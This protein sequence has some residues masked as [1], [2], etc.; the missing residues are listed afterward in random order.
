M[1]CLWQPLYCFHFV[2]V[3]W[4]HVTEICIY[5]YMYVNKYFELN[6]S[7]GCCPNLNYLL[8]SVA[9]QDTAT[10]HVNEEGFKKKCM[11][12]R[13][14]S[15]CPCL[16]E[17][18]CAHTFCVW[19]HCFD[20]L[21]C[22]DLR[23]KTA[24]SSSWGSSPMSFFLTWNT[25]FCTC[26]LDY[27]CYMQVACALVYNISIELYYDLLLMFI[28]VLSFAKFAKKNCLKNMATHTVFMQYPEKWVSNQEHH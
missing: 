24:S 17:T 12:S 1:G 8:S 26:V 22:L 6:D 16:N 20:V 19:L 14:V 25:C 9:S 15:V 23:L 13:S 18:V 10:C 2:P 27:V 21:S 3:I 5:V 11:H 4:L 28:N 7:W